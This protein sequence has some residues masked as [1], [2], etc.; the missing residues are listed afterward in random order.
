MPSAARW[1]VETGQDAITVN[2][3]VHSPQRL[4]TII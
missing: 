4:D 1:S 2:D 3:G